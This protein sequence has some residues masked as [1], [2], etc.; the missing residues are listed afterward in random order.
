[1]Q[2]SLCSP[3]R[4]PTLAAVAATFGI[5]TALVSCPCAFALIRGGDGNSPIPDP[6][7]PKGAA[8]IFNHGARIAYWEGPPFGGGQ[9]H[10]EYRGGT[11]AFNGVLARFA[12]VDVK[13][14]RLVVHDG[15]GH[16]FWLNPN[17]EPDKQKAA[18]VDWTFMVWVPANWQRPRKGPPSIDATDPRD[19]ETGPPAQ[20]DVYTGGKIN[21]SDVNVPEGIELLDQRLEAHGF[22]AAD[23]EVLEG[24]VT[25]VATKRPLAAKVRLER[26]EA[27]EQGG[28][29][30]TV[31]VETVADADGKWVIKNAPA[32]R[33]RL[34][35]EADGY[36]ARLVGY[37]QLD[38]QPGWQSFEARLSRPAPVSGRVL[39]E[40]GK[41]IADVQVRLDDVAVPSDGRYDSPHDFTARTDAEGRFVI[42]QAPI[43]AARIWL[44]KPGYCRPGLG[45]KITTP[46]DDLELRMMRSAAARVT[47]DFTRSPR[48]EAY[49]VQIEPE[50]GGGVGTWGG[51]SL[52]DASNQ[53]SF[54]D[55]PPGQYVLTGRP[56][57]SSDDQQTNPVTVELKGGET[58]EIRLNA[59]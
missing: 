39:D 32:G 31:V 17:R 43:A 34:V 57:P 2:A 46:V 5:L 22:T 8:D 15:V 49:I 36:A 56:N 24:V 45:E 42:D 55:I 37:P 23:G 20:I 9:W 3:R 30:Y 53:V 50:G 28:Y 59:K 25:D 18:R 7:W 16:S 6:G 12:K 13:T 10:A 41:P 21:W 27:Q 58:A 35:V 4:R 33:A 40:A 52:I 51:S 47:V 26:V 29:R 19:A 1:M 54:S 44:N 14:K 38:E 48:P 11:V